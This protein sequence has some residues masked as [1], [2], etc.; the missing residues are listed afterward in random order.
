MLALLFEVQNEAHR[1]YIHIGSFF[2]ICEHS[3][4]LYMH[5]LQKTRK[6]QGNASRN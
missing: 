3:T 1:F 2:A 5:L 6:K 4:T